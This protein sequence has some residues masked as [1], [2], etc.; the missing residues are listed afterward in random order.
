MA[1]DPTSGGV[2]AGEPTMPGDADEAR[3]LVF[4]TGC[5]DETCVRLRGME[6][7]R[8]CSTCSLLL[9]LADALAAS[10]NARAE[11]EREVERLRTMLTGTPPAE[12]P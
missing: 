5:G 6:P 8:M 7:A 11:A 12:K 10:E 3:A 2:T 9:R 4:G 1:A